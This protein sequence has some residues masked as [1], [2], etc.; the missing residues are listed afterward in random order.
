MSDITSEFA[1]EMEAYL[2]VHPCDPEYEDIA[3]EVKNGDCF[4][5]GMPFDKYKSFF[6]RDLLQV[7][8]ANTQD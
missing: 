5:F 4:D 3:K 7:Y 8:Y 2:K 6:Y 1:K